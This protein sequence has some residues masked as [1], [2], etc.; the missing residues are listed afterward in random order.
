RF[1]SKIPLNPIGCG[2]ED[3][4]AFYTEK[5]AF[6]LAERSTFRNFAA[7]WIGGAEGS[8]LIFNLTDAKRPKRE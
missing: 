2:F 8:S 6:F 5:R 3:L 4:F 7:K 1:A